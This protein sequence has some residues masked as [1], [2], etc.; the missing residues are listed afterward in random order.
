MGDFGLAVT[1]AAFASSSSSS[2]DHAERAGLGL[3]ATG[4]A[5]LTGALGLAWGTGSSPSSSELHTAAANHEKSKKNTNKKIIY[6]RNRSIA[7]TAASWGF[8]GGWDGGLGRLW[9]RLILLLF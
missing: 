1:G 2:S 7:R 3:A 9:R 5:D 8:L 6:S 4:A